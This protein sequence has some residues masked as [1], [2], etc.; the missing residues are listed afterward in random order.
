MGVIENVV[1]RLQY[2]RARRTG[3]LPWEGER[4]PW[5]LAMEVARSWHRKLTVLEVGCG[6]GLDAVALAREGHEVTG[7]D[8]V[9]DA[10][11]M[12]RERARAAAV[13]VRTVRSDVGSYRPG[14]QFDLVHDSGCLHTFGP[15]ER[16]QYRDRLFEWLA[17][18]GDFVLTHFLTRHALDRWPVG[19]RRRSVASLE[20]L[21][22]RELLL[23][24]LRTEDLP[25][26]L[27]AG[28]RVRLGHLH[29]RRK[30]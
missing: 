19:P 3:V 10:L 22:A 15:R 12:T 9:E 17:P 23:V 16:N 13:E 29:F 8:Y 28:L 24:E 14:V 21:F 11:R 7:L 18:G 4:E 27:A 5:P 25:V 26:R 2:L 30:G 6:S 1:Y 20:R